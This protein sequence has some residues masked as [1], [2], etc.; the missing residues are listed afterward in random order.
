MN[1][2]YLPATEEDKQDMLH[3]IG[4]EKMSDLFED[5]PERI[6][7]QEEMDLPEAAS[8]PRL[9]KE[10]SQL[11]R[12][13]ADVRTYPSFLGAGVYD[14]YIPSVV[15]HVIR[16]SEFYTAYTPYQPEISQGELQAIFE[17]QTMISEL[18]QMDIA[19]SSMYDGHT[20]LAEAALMAVSHSKM[21]K[22]KIIVSEGVHPEALA[23]LDT[24]A[25]GPGLTVVRVPLQGARTDKEVLEKEMDDQTA[26][27]LIQY[28]NFFGTVEEL[29][30]IETMVHQKDSLFIVS[31][32]PLALG[33]LTPPGD[34]GADIVI[35]DTQPLGIPM[36]LGGPH[37]GY[38]ATSRKLM[39]KMPG[40][41][42]GQ[43]VDKEGN[44]GFVLTLQTRE[45]HIRRDKATSNI[46]SNQ[47]LN[48]LASSVA[49]SALGKNGIRDMALQNLRKTNYFKE[50]LKHAGVSVVHEEPVFNEFVIHTQTDA[51]AVNRRLFEKGIIGGYDLGSVYED[52][53]G[54]MLLCVTEMRTR[55][56][57][58]AAA[59]ALK[60]AIK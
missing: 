48:A 40:R 22:T 27:V 59:A 39:R 24:Y 47:A 41:L 8:E 4:A 6:R 56:E 23:V 9:L 28:P 34:F 7:T 26:A 1:F 15:D 20:A 55:D 16:R 58:D 30:E 49:M 60:G 25:A 42:V 3:T 31:S 54:H 19:N 37:C 46:C 38:F 11:S 29:K 52:R 17:F 51:A 44:R 36:Q 18:T 50:K 10:M 12:K 5:I 57:I 35:G 2:R 14:H 21:K 45:Q 32:N 43:T 13:N 53:F 33:I